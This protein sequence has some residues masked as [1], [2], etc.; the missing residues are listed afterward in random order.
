MLMGRENTIS[1]SSNGRNWPD[2]MKLCKNKKSTLKIITKK[3][4]IDNGFIKNKQH[5]YLSLLSNTRH[6]QAQ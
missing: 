6:L 5:M 4:S 1:T 3:R 2:N